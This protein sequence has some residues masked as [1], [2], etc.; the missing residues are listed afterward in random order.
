MS[1]S[2]EKTMEIQDF[3]CHIY[4]F[5]C[6]LPN[7]ACFILRWLLFRCYSVYFCISEPLLSWN[8][9]SK[10]AAALPK[11]CLVAVSVTQKASE[12]RLLVFYTLWL[13]HKFRPADFT[14]PVN[15]LKPKLYFSLKTVNIYK[16][17]KMSFMSTRQD[18]FLIASAKHI[19]HT[20]H[21]ANTNT[22][23]KYINPEAA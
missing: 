11:R 2:F 7:I 1:V 19:S 13:K 23:F 16:T 17:L 15:H 4:S 20:R 9:Q 10:M 12:I 6:G 8:F 22:T 5:C 21:Y 3:Y 14:L 18:H